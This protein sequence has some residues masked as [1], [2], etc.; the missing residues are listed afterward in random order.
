AIPEDPVAAFA[1][2]DLL[3]EQ[4]DPRGELLRL[5]YTLTR[6]PEVPERERLEGR[7]RSLTKNG[8]V[9]IG[10]YRSVRVDWVVVMEFA[11]VPPGTFLMGS[12]SDE[13]GRYPDEGPR[14]RA[15]L[16][17]GFW[18]GVAPVTHLPWQAVMTPR[19]RFLSSYRKDESSPYWRIPQEEVSW[20]DAQELC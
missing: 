17:N 16:T 7:M 18:L 12:A 14:H 6:S 19:R 9:P 11:W 13:E 1:L 5:V 15:T 3:E 20:D 2:A 4:S 10:P 8:V